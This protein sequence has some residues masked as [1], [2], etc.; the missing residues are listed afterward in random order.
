MINVDPQEIVL[1]VS[2]VT[3]YKFFSGCWI[4]FRTLNLLLKCYNLNY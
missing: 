2:C 4:R 1:G 3:Y